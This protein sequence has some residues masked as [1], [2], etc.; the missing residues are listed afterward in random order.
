MV[1]LLLLQRSQNSHYAL[2]AADGIG[3]GLESFRCLLQCALQVEGESLERPFVPRMAG[4]RQGHYGL[5]SD[6]ADARLPGRLETP[7]H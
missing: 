5:V 7:R 1:I 3:S 6:P 2:P 4:D